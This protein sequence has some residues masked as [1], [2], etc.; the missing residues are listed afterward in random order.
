SPRSFKSLSPRTQMGVGLAFLAWGTIGLYVADS[1][2]KRF[3]F[4][5]SEKDR[6]ALPKI[7]VVEREGK[8]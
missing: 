1:A 2:E 5:P 7:S 8:S 6:E 3:G 4:E